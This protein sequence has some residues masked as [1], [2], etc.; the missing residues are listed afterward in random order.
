MSRTLQQTVPPGSLARHPRVAQRLLGRVPRLRSDIQQFIEQVPRAG[1]QVLR[2]PGKP[3]RELP[4]EIGTGYALAVVVE[5]EAPA[6]QHENYHPEGPRVD[7]LG[8]PLP[9]QHFRRQV[10]ARSEEG[11]GHGK[12]LRDQLRESEIDNLHLDVMRRPRLVRQQKVLRLHV[13]VYN[14]LRVHI[15]HRVCN[16]PDNSTSLL[17]RQRSLLHHIIEQFPAVHQLHDNINLILGNVHVVQGDDVGMPQRPQCLDLG[18]ELVG[19]GGRLCVYLNLVHDLA[20]AA[21]ARGQVDAPVDR[22]G[23]SHAEDL[24]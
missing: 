15:N 14:I 1:G 19:H 21:L 20:R 17:L 10:P 6:Q 24:A 23:G 5:R 18:V 4:P 3:Q 8:V 11:A 13:P 22:R 12:V 16:L 2:P 9:L 7:R